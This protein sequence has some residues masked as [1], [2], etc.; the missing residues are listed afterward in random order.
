MERHLAQERQVEIGR[1]GQLIVD[2]IGSLVR[3]LQK[4]R[5]HVRGDGHVELALPHGRND[6]GFVAQ[7]ARDPLSPDVELGVQ[8][9]YRQL[10]VVRILD[11]EFHQEALL[12]E[13]ATLQLDRAHGEDWA[14]E[15]GRASGDGAENEAE[16]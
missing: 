12:K 9:L 3:Q 11:L 7:A 10:S 14:L 16:K 1:S 2:R 5:R 6:K 15:P 8:T 13:I 4:R